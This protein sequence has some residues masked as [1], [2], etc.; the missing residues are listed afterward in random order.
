MYRISEMRAAADGE[1]LRM[2]MMAH[3]VQPLHTQTHWSTCLTHLS[4]QYEQSVPACLPCLGRQGILPGTC[5][6]PAALGRHPE[7]QFPELHICSALYHMACMCT[8]VC[9][10]S[11][12]VM[13]AGRYVCVRARMRAFVC[14]YSRKGF[15]L[16]HGK[17]AAFFDLLKSFRLRECGLTPTILSKRPLV[18][19]IRFQ[20]MG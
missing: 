15:R 10:C 1:L 14:V 12:P 4:T 9:L 8:W 13:S 16:T 2:A 17:E 18:Q 11:R 7:R 5:P 19:V 6:A 20:G 3:S